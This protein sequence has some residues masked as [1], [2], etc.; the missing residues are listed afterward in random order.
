MLSVLQRKARFIS[1]V[2]YPVT[3]KSGLIYRRQESYWQSYLAGPTATPHTLIAQAAYQVFHQ[4]I[5]ENY[6]C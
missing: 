5:V 4:C 3:S 2:S 6:Q 1:Q